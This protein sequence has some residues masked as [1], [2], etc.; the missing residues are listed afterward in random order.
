MRTGDE[1]RTEALLAAVDA[2][3]A[4]A[5]ILPASLTSTADFVLVN[6]VPCPDVT[7]NRQTGGIGVRRK[8]LSPLL[9][10]PP[11][12]LGRGTTLKAAF[13]VFADA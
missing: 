9:R 13:N 7:G 8:P 3:D 4:E 10:Q 2:T 11:E 12:R 5:V 1:I 6:G